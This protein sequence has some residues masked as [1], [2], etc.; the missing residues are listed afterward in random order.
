VGLA[1]ELGLRWQETALLDVRTASQQA[2]QKGKIS[3]KTG[4]KG[5]VPRDVPVLTPRQLD[6]IKE[7]LSA[8]VGISLV[9]APSEIFEFLSVVPAVFVKWSVEHPREK[10]F[11]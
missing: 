7:G 2:I 10:P 11:S 9:P 5:Q 6:S 4:T 3:L 8:G 1:R